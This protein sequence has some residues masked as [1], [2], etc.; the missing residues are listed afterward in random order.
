MPGPVLTF[1]LVL[2][3][4]ALL[5]FMYTIQKKIPTLG[6]GIASILILLT[7]IVLLT[8]AALAPR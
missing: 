6:C 5:V 7:F 8:S 4:I 2:V 1:S 3:A